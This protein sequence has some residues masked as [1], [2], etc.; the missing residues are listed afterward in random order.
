MEIKEKNNSDKDSRIIINIF[1]VIIILEI[2]SVN[3]IVSYLHLFPCN[4][5]KI[6]QN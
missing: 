2:I 1:F 6:T 5:E 4:A 3:N